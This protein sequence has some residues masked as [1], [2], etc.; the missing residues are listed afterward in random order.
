MAVGWA[1][2]LFIWDDG[3][4]VFGIVLIDEGCD[5]LF[6][7]SGRTAGKGENTG[8]YEDWLHGRYRVSKLNVFGYCRK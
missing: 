4:L 5:V 1:D 6:I 2:N 3:G 7:R 8:D